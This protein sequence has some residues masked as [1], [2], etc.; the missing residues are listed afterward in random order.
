MQKPRSL[1]GRFRR[2]GM[3]RPDLFERVRRR[4]VRTLRRKNRPGE[5]ATQRLSRREQEAV[6]Y[7]SAMGTFGR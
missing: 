6:A 1:F 5:G 4:L 7:R 2:Y 3:S